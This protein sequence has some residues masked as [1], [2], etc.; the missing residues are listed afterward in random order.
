MKLIYALMTSAVLAGTAVAAEPQKLQVTR[1][2]DSAKVLW[3][4]DGQSQTIE[5]GKEDLA[6][7]NKLADKLAALPAEKRD[8]LLQMLSADGLAALEPGMIGK[9]GHKVLIKK[10]DGEGQTEKRVIKV[11]HAG[12]HAEVEFDMLKQ[13][14]QD[15]KLSKEQLLELQQLLDKKF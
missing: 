15:S 2:A 7:K 1:Q 3:L 5:L 11:I 6:D 4:Q 14:L 9:D 13:L 8:K 10:L 12:D